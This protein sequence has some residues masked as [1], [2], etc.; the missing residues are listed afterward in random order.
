MQTVDWVVIIDVPAWR[1]LGQ[2]GTSDITFY[3][4]VFKQEAV[5]AQLL[6]NVLP[7][8]IHRRGLY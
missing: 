8:R 6:A 2:Y 5:A 4:L 1:L 7:Y 3:S